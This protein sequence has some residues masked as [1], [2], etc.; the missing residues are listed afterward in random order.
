MNLG[1]MHPKVLICRVE[2]DGRVRDRK[3]RA[4][5]FGDASV[6]SR[7]SRVRDYKTGHSMKEGEGKHP[8]RA[9][10]SR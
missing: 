4:A 5:P 7:M 3:A 10:T 1:C 2:S 9:L 8:G 6:S